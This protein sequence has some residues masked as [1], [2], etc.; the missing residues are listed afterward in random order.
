[1]C[2]NKL[3]LLPLAPQVLPTSFLAMLIALSQAS[4]T[5]LDFKLERFQG[6]YL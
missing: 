5:T 4:S 6:R 3:T 2:E 1:M